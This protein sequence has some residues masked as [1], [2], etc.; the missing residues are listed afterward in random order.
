MAIQAGNRER[1]MLDLAARLFFKVEKRDGLYSFCRDVDVAEPVR[2]EKL[3]L[4]EAK[5]LLRTWQ[6]RGEHGG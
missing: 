4:T 3:T 1:E 5:E 6:M 2:R